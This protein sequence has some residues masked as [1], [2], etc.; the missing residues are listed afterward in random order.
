VQ[1]GDIITAVN[2]QTVNDNGDLA[3]ALIS[4]SPGTQVT[5]SIQRGNSQ[6]SVKVTL[7]ERPTNLQG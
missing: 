6:L 3:S 7:G 4:L 2:G 5:L 1:T